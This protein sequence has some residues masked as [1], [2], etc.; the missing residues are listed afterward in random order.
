MPVDN[1][2]AYHGAY[3]EI[4]FRLEEEYPQKLSRKCIMKIPKD[5]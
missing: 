1:F 4:S 2:I 3:A 5:S